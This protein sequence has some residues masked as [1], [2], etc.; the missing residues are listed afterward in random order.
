[1]LLGFAALQAGDAGQAYNLCS[2]S[3]ALYRQIEHD[4]GIAYALAGLAGVAALRT[5]CTANYPETSPQASTVGMLGAAARMLA[6]RRK[7]QDDVE[8]CCYERIIES[9]RQRL[10]VDEF[11]DAFV[12]GDSWSDEQCVSAVAVA[13]PS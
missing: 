12:Q 1:M 9:L 13:R 2:E 8:R 5:T 3:L 4:A 11:A 6:G 10:T 7:V